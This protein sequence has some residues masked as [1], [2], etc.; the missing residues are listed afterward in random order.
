MEDWREEML[1][2]LK[3]QRL[4]QRIWIAASVAALVFNIAYLIYCLVA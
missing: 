3:K 1:K 2:S 4:V